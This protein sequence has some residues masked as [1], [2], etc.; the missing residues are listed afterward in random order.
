MSNQETAQGEKK[1]III[2]VVIGSI[3]AIVGAKILLLDPMKERAKQRSTDTARLTKEN[4]ALETQLIVLERDAAMDV[5]NTERLRQVIGTGSFVLVPKLGNS[6]LAAEEKVA[7]LA[8]AAGIDSISVSAATPAP[9][10]RGRARKADRL[11]TPYTTQLAFSAS[12]D[13]VLALV[14]AIRRSNPFCRISH[15]AIYANA[16]S[17]LAHNVRLTLTFPVWAE[18]T[19]AED[20]LAELNA[21]IKT[22]EQL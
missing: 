1:K 22:G 3:F 19:A 7:H 8:D 14:A 18:Q 11:L 12:Y 10:G 2:L 17:P 16:K 4:S 6:H 9:L 15:L 21:N 5:K 13:S 20:L